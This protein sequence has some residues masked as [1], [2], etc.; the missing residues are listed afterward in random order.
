MYRHL[1]PQG[2]P[3]DVEDVTH[4]AHPGTGET[5]ADLARLV[6][7]YEARGM[8]VTRGARQEPHA[9]PVPAQSGA[10]SLSLADLQGDDHHDRSESEGRADYSDT[11]RARR[12]GLRTVAIVTGLALIGVAG[13]FA[14]KMWSG[15]DRRDAIGD[16]ISQTVP[17]A[18]GDNNRSAEVAKPSSRPEESTPAV[19]LVRDQTTQSDRA[20]QQIISTLTA[21]E[22]NQRAG[23][24]PADTSSAPSMSAP[25]GRL[26]GL[27]PG[28]ASIETQTSQA[29]AAPPASVQA[30]SAGTYVVQLSS[31]RSEAAA[32]A[33]SRL[34][35]AK[36]PTMFAELKPF[37]RRSDLAERGVYYR[38]QVGPFA[39]F[40]SAKQFCGNLKKAGGDCVVQKN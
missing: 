33:T 30:P 9:L 16:V 31:Q 14:N 15:G 27:D 19:P 12:L 20:P 18:L 6:E 11:R 25:I 4:P 17:A 10:L 21:E 28:R 3:S 35:Q 38:A 29:N 5:L 39:T 24:N 32:Q 8:I 36:H 13:A 40:D 7:H 1:P 26:T 37:V 34:L 2:S 23:S 22:A